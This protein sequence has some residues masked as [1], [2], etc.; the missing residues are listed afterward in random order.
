MVNFG[1]K[2]P[3]GLIVRRRRGHET[4]FQRI[5]AANIVNK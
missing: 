2:L 1:K 4:A 3:K 5:L